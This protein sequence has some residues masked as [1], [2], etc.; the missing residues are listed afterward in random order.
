MKYDLPQCDSI[1][2]N[3]RPNGS[4]VGYDY[5]KQQWIDTDP[6]CRRNSAFPAGSA[7]N[8]LDY[9]DQRTEY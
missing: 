4:F 2:G 6:Q 9:V 1:R 3:I 8:P 7:S 5:S